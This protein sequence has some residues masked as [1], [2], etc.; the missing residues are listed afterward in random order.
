MVSKSARFIATLAAV[1]LSVSAHAGVAVPGST[2]QVTVVIDADDPNDIGERG[3]YVIIYSTGGFYKKLPLPVTH[4]ET[5]TLFTARIRGERV[6]VQLFGDGD[7]YMT[8]SVIGAD[9][10]NPGRDPAANNGDQGCPTM[11]SQPINTATGNKFRVA[12]DFRGVGENSLKFYRYY[13]SDPSLTD[14]FLADYSFFS[15]GWRHTFSSSI[16]YPWDQGATGPTGQMRVTR[17]D[18]RS[19][20]YA[21]DANGNWTSAQDPAG[22][23]QRVD[24]YGKWIYSPGNNTLEYFADSYFAGS[25]TASGYVQNWNGRTATDSY[26]R[27]IF[28]DGYQSIGTRAVVLPDGSGMIYDYQPQTDSDAVGASTALTSVTFVDSIQQSDYSVTPP[29]QKLQYVYGESPNQALA[30]ST[31]LPALLTGIVDENGARYATFMYDANGRAYYSSLAGGADKVVVA[32]GDD[33]S[34]VIGN[35]SGTVGHS[36][37]AING[38]EKLTSVSQPGGSGCSASASS[39]SFDTTG[40]LVSRDDFNGNRT[41]YAYDTLSRETVRVEG[42]ATS[43]ICASVLS[44]NA[45]LPV[46]SRKVTR[47]WHPDWR[48]ETLVAQPKRLTTLVY[49]GQ[50]DPTTGAVASCAPVTATLPVWAGSKPISVVCKRIVQATLD[51]DGHSGAS[52]TIDPSATAAVTTMTY[53]TTGQMLSVTDPG[54]HVTSYSYYPDTSATHTVGD[55]QA[56]VNAAGHTR[57]FPSYDKNGRVLRM[58]E[59]SG[60]TTDL[61]YW[62]RGWLKQT[63]VTPVEGGA[64]TTGYIYDAVGQLKNVSLPDGTNIGYTYDDAHRL[65]GLTDGAGN[66][67]TYVLDS[68]GHRVNE[69][70]KDVG[71]NLARN[72]TRVYDALDRLQ[73]ATGAPQ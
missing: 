10:P 64:R 35:D 12:A 30:P 1:A 3:E 2:I 16:S 33:D 29:G 54:N 55:L 15:R 8:Y 41:C 19:F 36:F 49:N 40:N 6:K 67:I 20:N 62:P 69:T 28:I 58:V 45:A 11:T 52:A 31:A 24:S 51:A 73:A 71:G 22:R 63:T 5:L 25:V 48:Q 59:P 23:L 61:T 70:V 14:I 7:E 37:A 72:V 39:S 43:A 46:G 4:S 60:A 57:T 26:G 27:A 50:T 44:A 21:P 47:A 32:Y 18:G 17:P 68:K 13:N 56:V 53:N 9:N 66:T 34:S 65:T 42:L 38:I